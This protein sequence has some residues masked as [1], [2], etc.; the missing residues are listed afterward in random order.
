MDVKMGN[1]DIS[2]LMSSF[3]RVNLVAYSKRL[4]SESLVV[5]V[6]FLFS[7]LFGSELCIL[8]R[9]FAIETAASG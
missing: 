9:Y 1:E 3:R 6:F 2:E 8:S 7:F 4:A 5:E